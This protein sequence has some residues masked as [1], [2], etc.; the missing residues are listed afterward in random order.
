MNKFIIQ[1]VLML[2]LLASCHQVTVVNKPQ[3]APQPQLLVNET[4]SLKKLDKYLSDSQSKTTA[5]TSISSSIDGDKSALD[6]DY[7]ALEILDLFDAKYDVSID[8]SK[9]Y[10]AY[11]AGSRRLSQ[12]ITEADV[13]KKITELEDLVKLSKT[14]ARKLSDAVDVRKKVDQ[15]KGNFDLAKDEQQ[16]ITTVAKSLAQ[17]EV[18]LNDKIDDAARNFNA[19]HGAEKALLIDAVLGRIDNAKSLKDIETDILM[20]PHFFS[21]KAEIKDVLDHGKAFLDLYEGDSSLKS[22]IERIIH[23][24]KTYKDQIDAHGDDP[25]PTTQI[26]LDAIARK[27]DGILGGNELQ[28]Y[29]A[30]RGVKRVETQRLRKVKEIFERVP[31]VVPRPGGPPPIPGQGPP[32]PP[33]PRALP[34]QGPPP[35]PPPAISGGQAPPQA[36]LSVEKSLKAFVEDVE[37]IRPNSTK[38]AAKT[39]INQ[40]YTRLESFYDQAKLDAI[41]AEVTAAGNPASARYQATYGNLISALEP[42]LVDSLKTA[43]E[44]GGLVDGSENEFEFSKNFIK[45]LKT[46]VN[47]NIFDKLLAKKDALIEQRIKFLK[48]YLVNTHP[49][50]KAI[51]DEFAALDAIKD[52]EDLKNHCVNINAHLVDILKKPIKCAEI[53]EALEV[54]WAAQ[55]A[56]PEAQRKPF[57]E[58]TI[59]TATKKQ[60]KEDY[61]KS[62]EK[63]SASG[64]KEPGVKIKIGEID[65][66]F[67]IPRGVTDLRQGVEAFSKEFL[68]PA[69]KI[70]F[71]ALPKT[72]A[73]NNQILIDDTINLLKTMNIGTDRN[74]IIYND[75]INKY[76]EELYPG[77]TADEITNLS[78]RVKKNSGHPL[79]RLNLVLSD[80]GALH[81]MSPFAVPP[82]ALLVRNMKD[83]AIAK[84]ADGSP[85]GAGV[86]DL[87]EALRAVSDA[88]SDPMSRAAILTLAKFFNATALK[89]QMEAVAADTAVDD[90]DDFGLT[91]QLG[92]IKTLVEKND[93]YKALVELANIDVASLDKV[94]IEAKGPPHEGESL[95]ERG[96]PG[97]VAA[98]YAVPP[99]LR[100]GIFGHVDGDIVVLERFRDLKEKLRLSLEAIKKTELAAGPVPAKTND[101]VQPVVNA[102]NLLFA[103][104]IDEL[105]KLALDGTDDD[106][107]TQV[108]DNFNVEYAKKFPR[109][110]SVV[111]ENHL[112]TGDKRMIFQLLEGQVVDGLAQPGLKDKLSAGSIADEIDVLKKLVSD[113]L[114]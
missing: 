58:T 20:D 7:R 70:D 42:Y 30:T 85:E 9:K 89:P 19:Y 5:L 88:T 1:I 111:Q 87:K 52:K 74:P 32:P 6:A 16:K 61:E 8:D 55:K 21:L 13:D 67:E 23:Q 60:I 26:M 28:T 59:L 25:L 38:A 68:L 41:K 91:G 53:S 50:I 109:L 66:G 40:A 92:I 2:L 62:F 106:K 4:Q 86:V 17:Q 35:P 47:K 93:G 110:K 83:A 98:K 39:K 95:V 77:M 71:A 64:G 84:I 27:L 73:Y 99:A 36:L 104:P 82:E 45:I 69:A 33:P 101:F 79:A 96:G 51:E 65:E 22:D 49:T 81:V 76:E 31:P 56:I 80:T 108:F 46:T 105:V 72:D 78:I 34:G 14:E 18:S 54:K 12:K 3:P 44:T 97:I 90:S 107:L 94:F 103:S 75:I 102:F 11:K 29:A 43:L 37:A 114:R 48:D 100:G 10:I 15:I 24:A 112:L 57:W 63:I 113:F